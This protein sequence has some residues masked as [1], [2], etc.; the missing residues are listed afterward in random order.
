MELFP[1][2]VFMQDVILC[3]NWKPPGHLSEETSLE[4]LALP[5]H[6]VQKKKTGYAWLDTRAET[7][8]TGRFCN[9]STDSLSNPIPTWEISHLHQVC[10]PPTVAGLS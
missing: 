1:I 3:W 6:P 9:N 10:G 4:Q 5:M 7:Q 2:P 8:L